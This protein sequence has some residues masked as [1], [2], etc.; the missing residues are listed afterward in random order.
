[1][2]ET[3]IQPSNGAEATALAIAYG[4]VSRTPFFFKQ[5]YKVNTADALVG[6]GKAI[7]NKR[8]SAISELAQKVRFGHAMAS[9]PASD[10]AGKSPTS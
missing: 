10:A 2:P 8:A 1:M 4:L 9:N 5:G 7:V 6:L 3:T